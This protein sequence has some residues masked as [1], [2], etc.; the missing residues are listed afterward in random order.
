MKA[1]SGSENNLFGKETSQAVSGLCE[2]QSVKSVSNYAM[3]NG[4]G[5]ALL[6][7]LE[8][9]KSGALWATSSIEI[10]VTTL[11]YLGVMFQQIG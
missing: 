5:W 9:V 7:I 10:V 6:G 4:E 11:D 8:Y 2:I 3:C 1:D